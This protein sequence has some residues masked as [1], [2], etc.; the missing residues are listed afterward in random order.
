MK[1]L[2]INCMMKGLSIRKTA[3]ASGIQRNTAFLWKQKIV[4]ALQNTAERER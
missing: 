3:L 1:L 2:V 4:D